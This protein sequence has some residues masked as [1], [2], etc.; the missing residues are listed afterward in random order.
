M[1]KLSLSI[2]CDVIRVCN[3]HQRLR[4]RSQSRQVTGEGDESVYFKV[5]FSLASISSSKVLCLRSHIVTLKISH[6]SANY[7]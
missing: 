5:G 2:K 1:N 7:F 3:E 6:S 4:L